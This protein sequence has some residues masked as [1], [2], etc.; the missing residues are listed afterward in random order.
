MELI[1]VYLSY[2]E[3]HFV[4]LVL[5]KARVLENFT[6]VHHAENESSSLAACIEILN[7][8]RVSQGAQIKYKVASGH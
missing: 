5:S 1:D 8:K 7:F 3:L 6:I 4:K 2:N